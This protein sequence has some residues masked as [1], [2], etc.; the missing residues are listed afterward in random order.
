M[1]APQASILAVLDRS[2]DVPPE[3]ADRVRRYARQTLELADGFVNLARAESATLGREPVDLGDVAV[4][5]ADDLWPLA[6]AKNIIVDAEGAD[7]MVLGDRPLLTRMTA[8]LVS[9]AIKYS[10]PGTTVRCRALLEGAHA[11]LVI[12]DEGRGIPAEAL[13][14]LFDAFTR[15]DE[16]GGEIGAGLGLAF[17][18]RVAERHGGTVSAESTL[19]EG[20]I[21][22][23]RLP[24]Q[25]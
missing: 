22:T 12:A 4:E 14:T 18:R 23:V 15:A 9:N 6:S 7:V 11:L 5:A 24:A 10:E 2:E 16:R 25:Q 3:L 19:G 21:F 17:V 20:S 8:N 1:R 13:P